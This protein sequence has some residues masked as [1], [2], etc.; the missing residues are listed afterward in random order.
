[1]V[2]QDFS[3]LWLVVKEF[4]VGIEA[5]C[6]C[7]ILKVNYPI[8]HGVVNN[9]DDIEKI[10]NHTII[11]ELKVDPSK[12][13]I[14]L[15]DSLFCTK[16][17]REEMAKIMFETFGVPC[18]YISDSSVLSLYS[19]G[20]FTGFVVD[21]GDTVTQ[22]TPILDS[23]ALS[24]ASIRLDL[25]GRDLTEYMIKLL[26]EV[27][28]I[29]SREEGKIYAKFIKEKACFVA[30]DF[31]EELKKVPS[32]CY[33]LP[34]GRRVVVKDQRIRCPEVL[35]KPNMIGKEENG[36]GQIC[37]DSIQKCNKDIRKILLNNIVLS[38]GTSFFNGFQ[39]R[40]TK[41]I[42]SLVPKSMKEEVKIIASP[43]NKFAAWVGGSILTSVS[44]F[45]SKW[46]TKAEYE[47]YGDTIVHKKCSYSLY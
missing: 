2:T 46:I 24:H 27:G 34:D 42:K 13:N 5:E 35:F 4:F 6:K 15:T 1:M 40:L 8:E 38:G 29:L 18:L 26:N 36:F 11:E 44:S 28:V 22:F 32:F 10:L 23:Q 19:E 33:E 20:K 43:S 7:R 21:S 30:L 16:K 47:E 3:I 12:H 14:F 31:E 41:E 45:Q 37:Y 39:K 9:W 25:A 17:N